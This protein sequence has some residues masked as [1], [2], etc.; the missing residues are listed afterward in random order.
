MDYATEYSKMRHDIA[1]LQER[2]RFLEEQLSHYQ[3]EFIPSV[4]AG[5]T[6]QQT[7]KS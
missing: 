6:P 4:T 2:N 7:A 1:V 5:E 3:S